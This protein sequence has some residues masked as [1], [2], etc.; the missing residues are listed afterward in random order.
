MPR[1]HCPVALAEGATLD[2]P[3]TAARHVQVLRLQPGDAVALF[4]GQGGEWSATIERMG[5]SHVTVH[6]G[7]H[8]PVEREPARE[9]HLA[10]GVP[11][12]E[13]MDWLVEKAAELGVASLQPLFTERSVVRL[14]AERARKKQEHWQAVAAAACEQCG[15]NR[16]PQVHAPRELAGWTP[17]DGLAAWMLSLSNAA[18]PL[19]Q[20]AAGPG[21]VL[22][23]SG[24]EGGLSPREEAA[25]QARGF[26][27]LSLG[28]RVLRA[29]TA[30]LAAL[31][32]LTLAA[33]PAGA[34]S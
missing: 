27:P 22:L 8:D 18:L 26:R 29:E 14:P 6:V 3:P 17:P 20:L 15:G 9:V 16:V 32:G 10:V 34:G 33:S 13:R 25:A 4:D 30:P 23:L 2:L 12:N 28:P 11:A 1:L 5:R 7:R 19:A 24:P 21:P 31:A